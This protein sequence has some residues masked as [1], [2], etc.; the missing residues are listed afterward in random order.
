VRSKVGIT[1]IHIIRRKG[2]VT[3]KL[4]LLPVLLSIVVS[5]TVLFGGYFAYHSVAMENPLQKVVTSIP[6]VELV[7]IDLGGTQALIELKLATGT[8]LRD[9]YHTIEQNGASVLSSKELT[10]KVTG[11][12][13]PRLEQWWSSALFEVAQA[14]ETKQYAQIPRA[15]QNLAEATGNGLTVSTEMDDK[16]VYITLKDGELSKYIM[17]PR[18]PAKMG[19]WPNE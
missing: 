1:H 6:G 9:V 14:M 13:S 4:R 12:A 3:V 11:E 8:N 18:T 7:K 10:I 17:L 15:L 19:V 2:D 16:F 5:A